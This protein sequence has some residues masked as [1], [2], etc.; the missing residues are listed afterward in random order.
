MKTSE[1]LLFVALLAIA[2]AYVLGAD[3]LSMPYLMLRT[4]IRMLGA[5]ILS[6]I[7]SVS[8]GL[9]IVHNRKAFGLIFP[10]LDILQSVPILGYLPLAV[11]FIIQAIPILGSEV[12]SILLI[13][14]SMT[15]AVVFNVIEGARSIPGDLRDAARLVHMK[16]ASY[17]FDV[18]LP[19]VYAPVVSGSITGWG[20]GWYFLVAGEYVTFGKGNPYILPGVGSF[21]A[22]SAYSGDMIHSLI[23]MGILASMVLFMNIFVWG[24][25]LS[26]ANRFSYS[27]TSGESQSI[28][29]NLITRALQ[30]LYTAGKTFILRYLDGAISWLI[31]SL[32]V[33]PSV[34][35]EETKKFNAGDFAIIFLVAAA[36]MVIYLFSGKTH[37]DIGTIALYSFF[38]LARIFIGYIIALSVAIVIAIYIGRNQRLT[39]ALM[40]LFDVAQSVPAIAVFPIIVVFVIHE[41]GGDSGIQ[42]ASL[43]LLLTGMVWYLLFN[44]IRAVQTIPNDLIDASKLLRMGIVDKVQHVFLPA[45]FPTLIVASMQAFGGGWNASIVS[46]YITYRSE[47]F[48][49]DG[50]GYLLDVAAG[51]GDVA[52]ILLS[53]LA[54]IAII[55]I[56]NKTIWR[57]A[58]KRAELYKI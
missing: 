36:F 9:F 15:W 20:G 27:Q 57:T 14:T 54:M 6:L 5:Y 51:N 43:L 12:A 22:E 34:S 45:I 24:P 55:I 8:L 58:L 25:L 21:I 31:I 32:G 46:E 56:L 33:N 41:I 13:F 47:V 37:S 3:A 38:T 48:H 53:V 50:L 4:F 30:T 11:L 52:G 28:R 1:F 40:P 19:A 2:A 18:L 23:G 35:M 26:R 10:V 16:G 17:L 39:D 7:F 44:L 49:A 29:S 42:L